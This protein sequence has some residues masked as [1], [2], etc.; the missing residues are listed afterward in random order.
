MNAKTFMKHFRKK[1]NTCEITQQTLRQNIPQNVND[2]QNSNLTKTI[3]TSEI[4]EAIF[5]MNRRI[6]HRVS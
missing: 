4:K 1:Q 2:I 6:R 5:S 3:E